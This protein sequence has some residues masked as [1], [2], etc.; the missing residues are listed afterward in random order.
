MGHPKLSTF[1]HSAHLH[2]QLVHMVGQKAQLE[3]PQ[4]W[5]LVHEAITDRIPKSLPSPFHHNHQI[6][7]GLTYVIKSTT[8]LILTVNEKETSYPTTQANEKFFKRSSQNVGLCLK[9]RVQA[10]DEILR[11]P[12]LDGP[13]CV[14]FVKDIVKP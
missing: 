2:L 6:R 14:R 13:H 7:V 8:T 12:R 9:F 1:D 4:S 3:G 10:G 5:T 11:S